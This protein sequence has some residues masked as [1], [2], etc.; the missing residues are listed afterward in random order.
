[1]EIARLDNLLDREPHPRGPVTV[2]LWEPPNSSFPPPDWLPVRNI[3]L[4]IAA[5][6]SEDESTENQPLIVVP[7]PLEEL[8]RIDTELQRRPAAAGILVRLL[9]ATA[10]VPLETALEMESLAYGTLL[11]GIDFKDW[12]RYRKRPS[13]SR[14]VPTDPLFL[15]RSDD[16]LVITLNDPERHNAYSARMRDA[17][18]EAL[19]VPLADD[20]ISAVEITGAGRSLCSGADLGEF[21]SA[22]DLA[23]AH[24]VRTQQHVGR[25]LAALGERVHVRAHGAC[26]GAGIEIPAF[27]SRI[28]AAPGTFF[29]L[30]ELQMGLI[31]GAGGCVS[32]P[33]RIGR[34]RTLYMVLSGMTVRADR[35][36]RWGLIDTL[37]D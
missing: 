17:L 9:R 23:A 33:R 21:G 34:F 31:P 13:P 37:E 28:T 5:G 24:L 14:T 19:A 8:Q 6:R 25:A 11:G 22:S 3:D 7:D 15:E 1:M 29:R 2:A 18:V 20:S 30:P 12:L 27:A 36:L 26:I 4:V 10:G 35:A 16:R 32:I